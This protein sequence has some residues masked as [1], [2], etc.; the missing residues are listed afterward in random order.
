MNSNTHIKRNHSE[1]KTISKNIGFP[2]LYLYRMLLTLLLL[3]TLKGITP[4]IV[5]QEDVY[6][7]QLLEIPFFFLKNI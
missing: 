1:F 5:S 6:H 3:K 4:A 2:F 7:Y